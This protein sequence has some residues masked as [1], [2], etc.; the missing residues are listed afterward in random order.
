MKKTVRFRN[1]VISL[2]VIAAV[3]ISIFILPTAAAPGDSVDPLITLSYIEKELL[4]AIYSYIDEK[5][6]T[7][8]SNAGAYAPYNEEIP[9]QP[10]SSGKWDKS[11]ATFEL[12]SLK[13]NEAIICGAGAEL[14]LRM[15]RATVIATDKGGIANVTEAVDLAHNARVPSNSLL[16]VPVDDG[17]GIIADN[18]VLILVKGEYVVMK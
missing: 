13:T 4:P 9:A 6:V 10:Q 7:L 15:G 3:A 8:G 1:K 5:I 16:I 18:D 17:R 14:I 12:V 2:A 11:A